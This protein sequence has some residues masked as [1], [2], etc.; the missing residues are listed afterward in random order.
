VQTR[1][2]APAEISLPRSRPTDSSRCASSPA[3]RCGS[4]KSYLRVD[5][6]PIDRRRE[7]AACLSNVALNQEENERDG[8]NNDSNDESGVE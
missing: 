1:D 4:C 2:R 8:Q 6:P 3:T 7:R 5:T